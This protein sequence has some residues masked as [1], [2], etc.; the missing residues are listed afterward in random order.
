[1]R[2]DLWTKRRDSCVVV[3]LEPGLIR[4]NPPNCGTC[5]KRYSGGITLKNVGRFG[6]ELDKSPQAV[7]KADCSFSISSVAILIEMF[8]SCDIQ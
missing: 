1:M 3:S 4:Y 5:E 2:N 8:N 6:D 7:E